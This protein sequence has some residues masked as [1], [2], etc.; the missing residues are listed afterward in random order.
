MEDVKGVQ[1]MDFVFT[2]EEVCECCDLGV[3]MALVCVYGPW[4][5]FVHIFLSEN[6]S[7]FREA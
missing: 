4:F 1:Q 7:N 2:L 3:S 6:A 5:I